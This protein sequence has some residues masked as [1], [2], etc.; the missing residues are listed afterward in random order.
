MISKGTNSIMLR[1]VQV[2]KESSYLKRLETIFLEPGSSIKMFPGTK[3]KDINELG[4]VTKCNYTQTVYVYRG[5][6][7]YF[8]AKKFAI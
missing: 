7:L 5:P 8:C 2:Q 4:N 3:P 1:G 6:K